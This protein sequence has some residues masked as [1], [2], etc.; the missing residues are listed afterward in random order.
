MD[1][2][3]PNGRPESSSQHKGKLCTWVL[4]VD[5]MYPTHLLAVGFS[6]L[7]RIIYRQIGFGFSGVERFAR[8]SRSRFS[9]ITR[10][11]TDGILQCVA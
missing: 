4:R 1:L 6:L 5:D 2:W 11:I 9:Q 8:G 10:L 3:R 7:I